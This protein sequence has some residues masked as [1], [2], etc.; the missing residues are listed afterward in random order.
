MT[1]GHLFHIF[2]YPVKH[3]NR[4]IQGITGQGQ[5]RCHDQKR[6]LNIEHPADAKDNQDIVKGGNCSGNAE[7]QVKAQGA[8][9]RQN[10]RA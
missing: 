9:D 7:T 5:K 4:V 3:N 8:I 10:S 1:L 6:N 2:T